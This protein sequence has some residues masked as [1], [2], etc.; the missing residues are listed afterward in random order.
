VPSPNLARAIAGGR[1]LLPAAAIG[2]AWAQ[3]RARPVPALTSK[4][5]LHDVKAMRD[6][7]RPPGVEWVAKLTV[8]PPPPPGTH[9]TG[10][11]LSL[12]VVNK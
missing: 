5:L 10:W 11:S 12:D 9:H 8:G 2:E 1:S 3:W 6:S 4:M 7:V